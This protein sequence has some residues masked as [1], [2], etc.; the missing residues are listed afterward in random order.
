MAIKLY[1]GKLSAAT[2]ESKLSEVFGTYG[3]VESVAVIMDRDTKLSRGF[4]FVEMSDQK[5]A[6]AA[7]DALNNSELDG[8]HII[9]NA[10]KEREDR[11]AGSSNR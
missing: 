7:I 10:A 1:I 11:P 4:A 8:A 6:Q 2:T 3:N 5:A 9:V